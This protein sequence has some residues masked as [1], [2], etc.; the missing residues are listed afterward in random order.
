[1]AK[2]RLYYDRS[3]NIVETEHRTDEEYSDDNVIRQDVKWIIVDSKDLPAESLEE[4]E[5]K[6]RKVVKRKVTDIP[7]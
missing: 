4:L 2:I 7:G 5:I 1:M 3:G 6:R